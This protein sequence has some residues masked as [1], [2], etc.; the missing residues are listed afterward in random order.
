VLL[1]THTFIP[2]GDASKPTRNGFVHPMIPFII[3]TAFSCEDATSL[4]SKMQTYRTT[5]EH[6][7][8]MIQIVKDSVTETGCWDAKAD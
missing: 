2:F 3:A 7:T 6:R 4:I 5:E 1:L 8:E